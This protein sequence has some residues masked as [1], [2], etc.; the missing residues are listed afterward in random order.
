METRDRLLMAE[1]CVTTG[2]VVCALW[3]FPSGVIMFRPEATFLLGLGLTFSVFRMNRANDWQHYAAPLA[4]AVICTWIIYVIFSAPLA[5]RDLVIVVLKGLIFIELALSF[6][7]C[8]SAFMGYVQALSVPLFMAHALLIDK[9]HPGSMVL[10]GSYLALSGLA[11]RFKLS[12]FARRGHGYSFTHAVSLIIPVIIVLVSISLSLILMTAVTLP[13]MERAGAFFGEADSQNLERDYFEKQERLQKQS[14]DLILDLESNDRRIESFDDLNN[15]VKESPLTIDA[16][17]GEEGLIS[18]LRTSGA[19]INLPELEKRKHLTKSYCDT[20][21][22]FEQNRA[23]AKIA[24][25]LKDDPLNIPARMS[26]MN[27]VNR[28][29]QARSLEDIRRLP[30]PQE[31]A[32]AH[33]LGRRTEDEIAQQ[34]DSLQEWKLYEIY[35]RDLSYLSGEAEKS[36]GGTG[37]ALQE[38]IAGIRAAVNLGDVEELQNRIDA[39]MASGAFADAHIYE[40][41]QEA[42]DIK[43]HMIRAAQAKR[44]REAVLGNL[45]IPVQEQDQMIKRI[46]EAAKIPRFTGEQAAQS[47]MRAPQTFVPYQGKGD[48]LPLVSL[49]VRP[50]S[51]TVGRGD[52]AV[53]PVV[54][55][56][57][58]DG[59]QWDVSDLV[60]WR[61]SDPAIADIIAGKLS[62]RAVGEARIR[63]IYQSFES[64]PLQVT[65][66]PPKLVSI[67]ARASAQKGDLRDIFTLTAQGVWSDGTRED[68]TSRTGWVLSDARV[69]R[70]EKNVLHP[71]R[72]GISAVHAQYEGLMS[73]PLRLEVAASLRWIFGIVFTAVFW[74]VAAAVIAVFFLLY[75]AAMNKHALA[76]KRSDPSAYLIALYEI[77]RRILFAAGMQGYANTHYRH[78]ADEAHKRFGIPRELLLNM[79]AA[80]EE[81]RFSSHEIHASSVLTA[82]AQY[83]QTIRCLLREQSGTLRLRLLFIILLHRVPFSI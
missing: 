25:V 26:V 62:A 47:D 68:L 50:A 53:S 10:V 31:K 24:Q 12:D 64:S 48:P 1:L 37:G 83:N 59:S 20:K 63:A 6:M 51:I 22:K 36:A 40:K 82:S 54:I 11:M 2:M 42:L 34:L 81:A 57:A 78:L 29:Q 8:S 17:Q 58:K 38:I 76:K 77:L 14:M 79:T 72:L 75:L 15:L 7:L 56:T 69:F 60:I 44:A 46:E 28:I 5:Y 41:L 16:E 21:V 80:Y 70:I 43:A 71:R 27:H 33:S 52:E 61:S 30:S 66:E 13:K 74:S 3:L 49:S 18:L 9:Y 67:I 23:R 73:Q 32:Q 65:V 35:R 45:D 39:A 55:G 4:L 19:G